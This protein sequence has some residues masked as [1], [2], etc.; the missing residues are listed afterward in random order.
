MARLL[1]HDSVEPK[2][3]SLMISFQVC[4]VKPSKVVGANELQQVKFT[5]GLNSRAV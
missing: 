5:I 1:G 3:S 2:N 4:Q